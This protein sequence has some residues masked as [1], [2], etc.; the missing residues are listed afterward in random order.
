MPAWS[1]TTSAVIE[2]KGL[3]RIKTYLGRAISPRDWTDA[4]RIVREA[5][6]GGFPGRTEAEWREVAE[7]TFIEADE[8]LAPAFDTNLLKT[9]ENLDLS[10]SLPALWEPFAGLSRV[11][12]LVVRG[13]LSDLLGAQTVR[14]MERRHPRL[15]AFTVPDAGHAPML[16]E[17]GVPDRITAFLADG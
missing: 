6:T 3:A 11:P 16:T 13:G 7:A 12:V 17:P 2:A 10:S 14:E 5:G 4:T 15:T 9:L 1:S 8:R